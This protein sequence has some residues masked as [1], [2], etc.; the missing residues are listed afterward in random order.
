[1][2]SSSVS[3]DSWPSNASSSVH[4]LSEKTAS[5]ELLE[6]VGHLASQTFLTYRS[7][8]ESLRI[9]DNGL[10]RVHGSVFLDLEGFVSRI[11]GLETTFLGSTMYHGV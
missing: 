11:V 7:Y 1:V 2:R 9:D 6:H 10:V 5:V 3:R 8:L 4:D